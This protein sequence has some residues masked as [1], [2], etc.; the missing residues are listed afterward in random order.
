MRWKKTST[1]QEVII[2]VEKGDP[3]FYSVH[4]FG[5]L[6]AVG[7]WLVVLLSVGCWLFVVCCLLLLLFL[8]LSRTPFEI[9]FP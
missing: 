1:T 6:L 4:N 8:L 3:C 7:G 9:T 2:Y 5:W